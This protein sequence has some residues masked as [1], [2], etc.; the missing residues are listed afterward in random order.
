MGLSVVIPTFNERDALTGCLDRLAA[1]AR[2][3]EIIVVNGPSTDGTSG[4]V[5]ERDDV[6]VLI[7]ITSRNIN[8]A[9]NVGLREATNDK[10]AILAPAFR[11]E[12]SWHTAVTEC[13]SG[14]ADAVSGPIRPLGNEPTDE[15]RIGVER[16]GELTL[17]G[18]NLGLSRAA[19]T[20][21]DG[22]DETL[23]SAGTAD[24][25]RRIRGLGLQVVWHPDM[26]VGYTDDTAGAPPMRNRDGY[27]S[28]WERAD[29]PN[30]GQR[31]R[32]QA[33]RWAKNDGVG[34][35]FAWRIVSTAIQDAV[36]SA[37][38][39]MRGTG[40][41]SQWVHNGL[42]VTRNAVRGTVEGYRARRRDPTETRNPN[43]LSRT[44]AE[45]AIVAVHD[46]R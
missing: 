16:S 15:S 18:G 40:T 10:V 3:V 41:P 39:V 32:S 38:G 30:W 9:R 11:I 5:Q 23:T 28:T 34:P 35:R 37:V 12:P 45:G 4:V 42:A 26:T 44:G 6:N 24:L 29:E 36:G 31:Y 8:L 33:Y 14:A 21:L 46:R 7:D 13:L 25:A 2:D 20:A 17:V 1:H 22:F 19:V 43:G 27:V